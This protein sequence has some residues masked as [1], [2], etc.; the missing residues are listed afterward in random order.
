MKNKTKISKK[1]IAY[2][3]PLILILCG[4]FDIEVNELQDA[5]RLCANNK[6]LDIYPGSCKYHDITNQERGMFK[7]ADLEGF[8]IDKFHIVQ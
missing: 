6:I 2:H 8:L 3:T 7:F 4:E 1:L 5:L